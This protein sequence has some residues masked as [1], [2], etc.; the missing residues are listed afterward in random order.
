MELRACY[1]LV[2]VKI[3]LQLVVINNLVRKNTVKIIKLTCIALDKRILIV[4]MKFIILFIIGLI[5]AIVFFPGIVVLIT[6]LIGMFAELIKLAAIAMLVLI[7]V[8]VFIS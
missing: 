6:M 1:L 5:A 4:E 7:V 2:L 3:T 8:G